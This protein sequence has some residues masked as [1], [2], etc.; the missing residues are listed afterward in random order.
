MAECLICGGKE[1]AQYKNGSYGGD[2][3]ECL[4]CGLVATWPQPDLLELTKRYGS[5][6]YAHWISEEQKKRRIELWKRRA[7]VT[8][9]V[10]RSGKLL[11]VG[12]GE[13]LFLHT[14]KEL[15]YETAGLE[16]SEYAAGYARKEFGLEVRNASI[17]DAGFGDGTFDVITFWH[18]LEHL[19]DPLSALEKARRLLKP[20]G[21]LLVA[22]P[23]INDDLGQAFYRLRTGNYFQIYT[24]DSKEPH[25]YHF[26]T[27]TLRRLLEKAGFTL[28]RLTA[29]FAQVDPYW[30]V[31]EWVSFAASVITRKEMYLALL[32]V[33]RK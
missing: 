30:R 19:A 29:D 15:G 4:G 5:E 8:G 23:N 24:P 27:A 13:G 26:S 21:R 6:Y 7:K 2:L 9:K 33:A 22:V 20:G 10:C 28:E 3:R 31:I 14:V 12:C 25:L 1:F 18:V 32:A 17:G 11:D 16:L